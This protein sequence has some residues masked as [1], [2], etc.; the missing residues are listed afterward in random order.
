MIQLSV[1]HG[2]ETE[3]RR[4]VTMLVALKQLISGNYSKALIHFPKAE[5]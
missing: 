1:P 5:I 2:T 3:V 4:Y